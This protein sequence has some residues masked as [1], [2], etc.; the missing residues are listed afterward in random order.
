[1]NGCLKPM[2]FNDYD[3]GEDASGQVDNNIIGFRVTLFARF[4]SANHNKL[5][6]MENFRLFHLDY[7]GTT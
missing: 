2:G 7:H 6:T 3:D 5:T 4:G 1:V